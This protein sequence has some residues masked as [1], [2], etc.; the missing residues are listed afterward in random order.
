[1]MVGSQRA[2]SSGQVA[3]RI[4]RSFAKAASIAASASDA[5]REGPVFW[6]R[7]RTCMDLRA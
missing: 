3:A 5:A 7:G 2:N 4:S 6:C 1:M